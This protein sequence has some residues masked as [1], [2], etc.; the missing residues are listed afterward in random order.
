MAFD[1][2]TK[3]RAREA[4]K[5]RRRALA[6]A[7][8]DA[9]IDLIRHWPKTGKM[10][11]IAA[12]YLPIQNEIDPRPL[13]QAMADAGHKLALP[14]IQRT[15]KPLI[16]RAFAPGDALAAGPYGTKQPAKT[17]AAVQPDII[18]LPLLAYSK[19]GDRLGYGGGFYD[20]PLE[21]LRAQKADFACGLAYAGQGILDS[22][23][24]FPVDT[25]DQKMDAVLTNTGILDL[26]KMDAK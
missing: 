6:A 26:T 25:H 19:T 16:F 3:T 7:A 1:S 10:S 8:P 20:R 18:F 5:Q 9:G 12:F 21:Q 15:G 23:I 17:A 13:M 22:D 2:Y 14:C 11:G 4:A 24:A